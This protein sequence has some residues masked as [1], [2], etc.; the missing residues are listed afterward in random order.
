[1]TDC[2]VLIDTTDCGILSVPIEPMHLREA[3]YD[4]AIAA[5]CIRLDEKFK[6]LDDY[7]LDGRPLVIGL[8][9]HAGC[10]KDS[11]IVNLLKADHIFAR[12]A[13]ADKIREIG[14][15][16][17]FTHHQMTDRTLK[18]KVD[19]YWGISPRKFMQLVG[20]EMF[21]HHLCPDVWIK[22][23]FR[24]LERDYGNKKVVFITDVRFPNEAEAIQNEGGIVIRI[25]RPS[26]EISSEVLHHES[27]RYINELNV[28]YEVLNDCSSAEAWADKFENDT[29]KRAL[30]LMSAELKDD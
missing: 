6:Y 8:A 10:G 15:I 23:L 5:M 28:D 3:S 18:E 7:V 30:V 21:R 2:D 26:L 14:K 25:T 1:M 20:S 29:L 11:A 22:A 19:E 13:F 16:F 17:G 4:D 27:E 9:G 12:T 24:T